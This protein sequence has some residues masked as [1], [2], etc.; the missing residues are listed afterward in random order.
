MANEELFKLLGILG[1][2]LVII[3]G[4][5]LFQSWKKK[6]KAEKELAFSSGEELQEETFQENPQIKN[7]IL[8]YKNSYSKEQ[9]REGLVQGHFDQNSI[10]EHINRYF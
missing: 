3:I 5:Y 9:I 2:G 7:Y 6:K 10:D 4:G 1:G 8:Q